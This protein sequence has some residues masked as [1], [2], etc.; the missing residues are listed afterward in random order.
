MIVNEPSF[1]DLPD[2]AVETLG[3]FA[4][5]ANDE[6]FAAKEN[7]LRA[8]AA[9]W[10]EHDYTDRGKWM[11]GWETRR[12]REPGVDVCIVRLGLPG[13]VR[14]AVVD[15]AFFRGNYPAECQ[16]EGAR[17][18]TNQDA[19]AIHDPAT[20]WVTLV[21]RSPLRGDAKN[22]FAAA[23]GEGDTDI[24]ITHVKLTI[25][26]D[27]GVARLRIHGEPR[28]DFTRLRSLGGPIDL[29]ALENGA[30]SLLCSDMFFGSRHNLILPGRPLDMGGGWETRRRRGPGHDWN[31]IELAAPGV[32]RRVELDTM[33]FKG[34][35]P[36]R[37]SLD[38]ADAEGA[39]G[40]ALS[41]SDE[42][43]ALLPETPLQPHSR[44]LF[45]AELRSLGR[46]THVRLNVFPDGGVARLRCLGEPLLPDPLQAQVAR[47]NAQPR[48]EA[49]R[50]LR[51]F[52]GSARWTERMADAR[53]LEDASALHRAADRIWWSLEE[54]DWLEA[55]AAH[56]KIGEKKAGTDQHSRW[57]QQEQSGAAAANEQTLAALVEK[58]ASYLEKFG[59]IYIVGAAGKTATE[60]LRLLE[61]RL[62]RTRAQELRTAAEE[63]ARITRLRIGKWLSP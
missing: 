7:L 38:A 17:L 32:I 28:G 30:R 54:T 9:E 24:T 50:W 55:F 15:T 41:R 26:P 33:H 43:R 2:L 23:R 13:V 63:Q 21:P 27:G 10:R 31:L 42:W 12:R 53:P 14:G 29:A 58:N 47:L 16:L 11:D 60:M 51:A 49:M 62:S 36:G 34:N 40:E 6:F 46:V 8:R 5:W 45:E 18:S 3:G 56:P 48:E 35:A 1:I 19:S 57:S 39:S 59:F 61:Q 20:K 22:Q 44:H 52:C 25:I 4:I 37:A